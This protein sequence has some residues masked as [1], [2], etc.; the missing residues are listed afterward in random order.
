MAEIVEPD[1]L[2]ED[3]V[4]DRIFHIVLKSYHMGK[5][6]GLARGWK[7][8]KSL[9][10]HSLVK[11]HFRYLSSYHT[12]TITFKHLLKTYYVAGTP[13]A[14]YGLILTTIPQDRYFHYLHFTDEETEAQSG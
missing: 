9:L 13:K 6:L 3:L 1:K 5:Y 4:E 8:I 10:S 12:V 11:V 2:V 7:R 14:F